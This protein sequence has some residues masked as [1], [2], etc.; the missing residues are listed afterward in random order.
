MNIEEAIT[1]WEKLEY[2]ITGPF[3]VVGDENSYW[4]VT[5]NISDEPWYLIAAELIDSA[6]DAAQAEGWSTQPEDWLVSRDGEYPHEEWDPAWGEYPM[7]R[8]IIGKAVRADHLEAEK[9]IAQRRKIEEAD[10]FTR[11]P[12]EADAEAQRATEASGGTEEWVRW[13]LS[14]GGYTIQI[15]E[16]EALYEGYGPPGTPGQEIPEG[17]QLKPGGINKTTGETIWTLERKAEEAG[18][19]TLEELLFQ[20]IKTGQPLTAKQI[21]SIIYVDKIRDWLARRTITPEEA[22]NLAAPLMENPQHLSE[23]MTALL[24]E[25]GQDISFPEFNAGMSAN[26]Q[27]TQYPDDPSGVKA[28]FF[29]GGGEIGGAGDE[30]NGLASSI[31]AF[32]GG[33]QG[34]TSPPPGSIV[35]DDVFHEGRFYNPTTRVFEPLEEFQQRMQSETLTFPQEL[36]KP[37]DPAVM[38]V[39]PGTQEPKGQ[40]VGETRWEHI[41]RILGAGGKTDWVVGQTGRLY[42]PITNEW[43]PTDVFEARTDPSYTPPI[44]PHQ[45]PSVEKPQVMDEVMQSPKPGFGGQLPAYGG[46]RYFPITPGQNP[47]GTFQALGVR[48]WNKRQQELFKARGPK[49]TVFG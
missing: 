29:A 7:E 46:T 1:I 19:S 48:G 44:Y 14:G 35:T 36:F 4:T 8:D 42:N 22:F 40:L 12:D 41:A 49:R 30:G 10:F 5:G 2:T 32:P 37:Q 26:A 43:E 45:K 28:R 47:Q 6:T 18:P 15:K 16:P 11:D 27:N 20:S 34:Y 24:S 23:M 21:D 9:I 31:S 33:G 39:I 25:T 13:P 38:G 17:W 3:Q